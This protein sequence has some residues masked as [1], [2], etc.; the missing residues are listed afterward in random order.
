M[1]F[2][3]AGYVKTISY[4]FVMTYSVSMGCGMDD[5][6]LMPWLFEDFVFYPI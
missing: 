6:H 4:Y 2:A 1:S 5:V 3:Y